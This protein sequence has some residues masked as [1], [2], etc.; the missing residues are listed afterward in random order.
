MEGNNYL[1]VNTSP[2][3]CDNDDATV[4]TQSYTAAVV[5]LRNNFALC[6]RL[7]PTE[8]QL[9]ERFRNT[10]QYFVDVI[11]FGVN[12][13]QTQRLRCSVKINCP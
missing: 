8:R 11:Y 9:S 1:I 3:E 4:T 5:R 13:E 12:G 6:T 7:S 10:K 2:V